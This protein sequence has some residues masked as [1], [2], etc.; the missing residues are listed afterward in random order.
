MTGAVETTKMRKIVVARLLELFDQRT[1]WHRGLWQVGTVVGLHEVLEYADVVRQQGTPPEGLRFAMNS[2]VRQVERDAGLG[3]VALRTAIV[4]H[5]VTPT[6]GKKTGLVNESLARSLHQLVE[7]SR[8]EY[9][10]RWADVIERGE[11]G[12][13]EVELLARMVAAHLL[14]LGFSG[15]HLHGWV[16][17]NS[18]DDGPSLADLLRMG[19]EMSRR[20]PTQ[21]TVYVPFRRLSE[22]IS[23]DCHHRSLTWDELQ[24][25]TQKH[26]SVV[27]FRAGAGAIRFD[28]SALDP[29]TAV[30]EAEVQVRRFLARVAVGVGSGHVSPESQVLV[31]SDE[32]AEWLPLRSWRRNVR[33]PAL[34]RHRLL[35]PNDEPGDWIELDDAFELIALMEQATSWASVATTW[36]AVEGLLSGPG[37]KGIEAADRLAAVVTCGYARAELVQLV[38]VCQ[39][40]T[41]NGLGPQYAKATMTTKCDVMLSRIAARSAHPFK[42]PSD[43]AAVARLASLA[44]DPKAV[45]SRVN[46]YYRDA[47]RRLYNQRNLM[48]HSG[49]FSSVALSTTL[50]TV[51]SLVAAGIDRLVNAN[52]RTPPVGPL[53][54]AARAQNELALLGTESARSVHRMLD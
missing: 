35:L 14:D 42:Q 10:E 25:I 9:L 52:F 11:L 19:G 53:G 33:I 5:L 31:E 44:Q 51:P 48:M 22:L 21:Y 23:A 15:D 47:F 50:R 2:M 46:G 27:P 38:N 17:A 37:E 49:S 36:A 6:D 12:A 26:S 40:E 7:R 32:G 24:A 45:L 16:R 54:L 13:S 18:D 28:A 20:K 41:E 8:W 39:R 1:S 43:Q 30:A 29:W 4:Q 3:E 34:R